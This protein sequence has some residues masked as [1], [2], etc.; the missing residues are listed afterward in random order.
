[1]PLHAK[2]WSRNATDQCRLHHFQ[3]LLLTLFFLRLCRARRR[4]GAPGSW[5]HGVAPRSSN[6]L[7]PAHAHEHAALPATPLECAF[8]AAVVDGP[9]VHAA[10][11][12]DL[13][14][15]HPVGKQ[16]RRRCHGGSLPYNH[17]LAR[18]PK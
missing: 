13:R 18:K 1:M 9:A 2:R 6:L 8:K 14:V 4:R 16:G 5:P 3:P 11:Q 17:L 15:Q 7:L 10:V 12:P